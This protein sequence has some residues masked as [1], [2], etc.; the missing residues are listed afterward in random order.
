MELDDDGRVD[1]EQFVVSYIGAT[2]FIK[3]EIFSTR[4]KIEDVKRM[5][6]DY[7]KQLDHAIRNEHKNEHGIMTDSVLKVRVIQ[8]CDLVPMDYGGTSDPYCILEVGD[9]IIETTAKQK[10]LNPRWDESFSFPITTG[11]EVGWFRV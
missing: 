3:E 9:E 1:K 4:D 6:A 5:K 8:A 10:T 7:E 2:N 11:K